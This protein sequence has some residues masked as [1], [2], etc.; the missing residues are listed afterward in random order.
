M[1]KLLF[2]ALFIVILPVYLSLTQFGHQPETMS[3]VSNNVVTDSIPVKS[4]SNR[5]K[6]KALKSTQSGNETVSPIYYTDPT[7]TKGSIVDT[8]GVIYELNA[9]YPLGR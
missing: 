1:Q 6:P 9:F 3:I 4:K 7:R 8:A 2:P 5:S